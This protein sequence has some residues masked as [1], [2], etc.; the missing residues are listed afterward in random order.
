MPVVALLTCLFIGYFL[1]PRPLIE[2][3]EVNGPFRAK[4]MFAV[5]IKYVAPVCILLI[6]VSSVLNAFGIVKI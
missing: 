2:E 1:S 6:L 3:V 4:R 5:M